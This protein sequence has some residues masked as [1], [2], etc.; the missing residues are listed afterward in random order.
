MKFNEVK[1]I[2]KPDAFISLPDALRQNREQVL[3]NH[4]KHLNSGLAMMFNLLDFNKLFV[5]AEGCRVWDSEGNEYLDF[6]GA[7]GALNVGHNH[8]RL[9]K[10]MEQVREWPNLLQAS[11][12]ALSGALAHNLAAITP[13]GLERCFFCNSGAEAVEGALKLARAATGKQRLVYC[14]NSFHGKTMGALSVTGRLKYQKAFQ[15]LLKDAVPVPY[16]DLPALEKILADRLT[17]AFILEPIQGEAGIITPPSG[18]LAEAK[19]LCVKY[20]ALMILDEI[21]TGLGRTGTMFA[22]EQEGLIPDILCLAKSLG[23]GVMPIGVFITGN[24]IW[25][26][27]YGGMEKA[28]LHTST[29]GGNTWAMAAGITALEVLFEENLMANAKET[30]DYLLAGLRRL[31]ETHPIIKETRGRGLLTGIEFNQTEGF[32]S[33]ATFGLAT[34]LSQEY[35]GSLIAGELM[36]R[37]RIITAYTL[38][39]PNVIRLEPPLCVTKREIDVLLEALDSL[40]NKHK[41]FS[42]LAASGAK[43]VIKSLFK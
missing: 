6:L 2:S 32:A 30:G 19:D 34:K 5:R 38:N 14:E 43:T 16:G 9:L 20:D 7:Y 11:L 40:L 10:A 31:R 26:K 15:P 28:L 39:N 25:D 22:F 21:Q 17:A 33:K 3:E 13:A 27:A 29:F 1:V 12:S 37:H 18:Y 24:D 8:P 41:S 4:K 23:G 42:G 35:F 36:N